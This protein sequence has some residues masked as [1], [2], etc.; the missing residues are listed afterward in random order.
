[1]SIDLSMEDENYESEGS[2]ARS[3]SHLITETEI[4]VFYSKKKSL[5]QASGDDL[6]AVDSAA[7]VAS[8]EAAENFEPELPHVE[9]IVDADAIDEF[10]CKD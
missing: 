1:M 2:D 3:E 7:Q 8:F 4:E 6:E 10:D 9:G 5:L